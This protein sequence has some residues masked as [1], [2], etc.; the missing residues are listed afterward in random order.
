MHDKSCIILCMDGAKNNNWI[1]IFLH[2][3]LPRNP[4]TMQVFIIEGMLAFVYSILPITENGN[5]YVTTIRIPPTPNKTKP[6]KIAFTLF[7]S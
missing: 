5:C 3:Y 1:K 6:N 2:K 7:N 4:E